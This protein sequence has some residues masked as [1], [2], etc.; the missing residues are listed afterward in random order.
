MCITKAIQKY[1]QNERTLFS[2]LTAEGSNSINDFIETDNCTY[3]LSIAYDYLIYNFFSALS[4][5]NSDTAAWTSMRVAIERVGGGELKDEYI[6]DAIKI[7]KAI[8]MLNLFGTASTSLSKSLLMDY[9]RFAM[10][11]ENPE[12]VLK[13]VS[14]THL[15]LPTT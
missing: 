11:I 8:G 4:E 7:V 14:Y 2:F 6:E 9:A 5:I 10:N 3:N 13:P 1:G 15:T 12:A